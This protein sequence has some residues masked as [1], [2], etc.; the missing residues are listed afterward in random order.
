MKLVM[1]GTGPFAV[2]VFGQLVEVGHEVAALFTQPVREVHSHHKTVYPMRELAQRHG[3]P[4]FDPESVN[5]EEAAAVLKMLQADLFV[6]CDYGQILSAAC[7]GLARQGGINLHGSLLPKYRGAA[8]IQW[9]MYHGEMETGATV[10]HMTPQLDAGPCVGQVRTPITPDDTASSLEERLAALGAELVVETLE[11]MER[12]ALEPL[13]QDPSLAT[14]APR[15]KKSDGLLNW[16]R[17]ASALRNQIRAFDPWPK[18]YTYWRRPNA[19]SVRLILGQVAILPDIQGTPGE[20][21]IADGGRLV[22]AAQEGALE[23]L[24]LQPAGKRMLATNEF[25]RGYPVQAG[26]SFGAE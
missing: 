14:R 26:E 1:M 6:V 19:A 11:R 4:I 13:P 10:I 7:L 17:P 3:I 20:V 23:I 18:S 16:H 15:L 8:P 21:Q 12:G 2:P 22:V 9:A 25:L 24:N 5:T